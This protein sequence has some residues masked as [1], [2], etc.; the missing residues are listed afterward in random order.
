VL[1][2]EDLVDIYEDAV[3]ETKLEGKAKLIK[4]TNTPDNPINDKE[5]LEFWIVQFEGDEGKVFRTIKSK[6]LI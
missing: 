5:H 6:E 3:T 2:V 1:K 4:K